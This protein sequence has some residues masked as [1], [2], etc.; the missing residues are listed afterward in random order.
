MKDIITTYLT[1]RGAEIIEG[2]ASELQQ[3]W[4]CDFAARLGALSI[5]ETGF[6]AGFSASALL[7]SHPDAK[8]TSFDLGEYAHVADAKTLVDAR[9]PGRHRLITGDSRLTLPNYKSEELFDLVFIDGAHGFR[10]A[11]ADILNFRRLCKPDAKIIMDDIMP[12]YKFG[13]GPTLAW[14]QMITSGVLTQL[15]ELLN[16]GQKALFPHLSA[17]RIWGVGHYATF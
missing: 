12:W 8:V 2:S 1:S 17:E 13:R 15:E 14:L 3:K 11:R 16:D 4:L 7:S 9:F 10:V 5:G 6:N